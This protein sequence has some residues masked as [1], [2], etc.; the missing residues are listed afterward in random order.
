MNSFF[1]RTDIKGDVVKKIIRNFIGDSTEFIVNSIDN[2]SKDISN[3]CIRVSSLS[4]ELGKVFNLSVKDM[5]D[6]FISSILHDIGKMFISDEIL[7]N[8]SKLTENEYEIVKTHSL[9]GYIVLNRNKKLSN[10]A[11]IMLHHHER[12]DGKGYPYGLKGKE[13]PF[14]S[15]IITVA[16]S[17]DA[18]VSSRI[19]KPSL[20][21]NEAIKELENG[22]FTQFDG[23]I[24]NIFIDLI[25]KNIIKPNYN[26]KFENYLVYKN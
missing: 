26:E 1:A 21:L 17:F 15:R 20:S 14:L 3:H 25:N 18:M 24:V 16:D 6:L 9:K 19:Y 4:C 2:M 11:N 8:P 12:Y 5:E 22:R 10:I 7:N 13:I 23:H